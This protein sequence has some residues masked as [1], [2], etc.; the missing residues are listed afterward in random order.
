M[1]EP[2]LHGYYEGRYS[3]QFL[4]STS[5]EELEATLKAIDPSNSE[6]DKQNRELIKKV[7]E[8]KRKVSAEERSQEM[9]KIAKKSD[10]RTLL[11]LLV[12]TAGLVIS[13]LEWLIN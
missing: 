12:A 4:E 6:R 2:D 8:Q 1:L 3:E 7:L 9:Y 5:N 13:I 11:I 10:C